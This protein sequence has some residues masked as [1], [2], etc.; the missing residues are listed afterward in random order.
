M[1]CCSKGIFVFL[2]NFK[3]VPNRILSVKTNSAFINQNGVMV[4]M[5]VMIKVTKAQIV[6]VRN[7]CRNTKES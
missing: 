6:M 7:L 5:T 1:N 4:S 2:I 3:Y